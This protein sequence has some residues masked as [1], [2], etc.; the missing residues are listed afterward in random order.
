[1]RCAIYEPPPGSD[2]GYHTDHQE[3]VSGR[4]KTDIVSGQSPKSGNSCNVDGGILVISPC[5]PPTSG[6]CNA[7]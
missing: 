5:K 1:M 7:K 2:P 6:R 4:I 3:M